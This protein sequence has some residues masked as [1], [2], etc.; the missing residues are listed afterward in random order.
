MEID[1]ILFAR[2]RNTCIESAR[3]SSFLL[4]KSEKLLKVRYG[5]D[6][7][8]KMVENSAFVKNSNFIRE[9]TEAAVRGCFGILYIYKKLPAIESYYSKI[10]GLLPVTLLQGTK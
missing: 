2:R 10:V 1:T 3:I 6:C 9:N 5:T 4:Q 7:L 8:E